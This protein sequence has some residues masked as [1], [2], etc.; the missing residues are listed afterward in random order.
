MKEWNNRRN[1]T[2]W[3][4]IQFSGWDRRGMFKGET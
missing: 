3:A 2:V 1:G 4:L